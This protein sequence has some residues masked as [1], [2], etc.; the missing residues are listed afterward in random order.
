MDGQLVVDVAI[1]LGRECVLHQCWVCPLV[2]FGSRTSKQKRKVD[3]TIKVPEPALF[4]RAFS[5]WYLEL[6]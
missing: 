3:D 4:I 6:K 2:I 5:K 1:D